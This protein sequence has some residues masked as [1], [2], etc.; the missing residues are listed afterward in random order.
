MGAVHHVRCF[1]ADAI[2]PHRKWGGP[3]R[4]QPG[5]FVVVNVGF[6]FF[7]SRKKEEEFVSRPLR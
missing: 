7:S 1:H 6:H 3:T 4:R 5:A 2:P